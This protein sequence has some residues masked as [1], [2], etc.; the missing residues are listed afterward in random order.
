MKLEDAIAKSIYNY[1]S[2]FKDSNWEKSRIKVLD[3]LFLTIGN[4]YEWYDGYLTER[5]GK[6]VGR[7]YKKPEKYGKQ[8]FTQ[9][10]DEVFFTKPV[11]REASWS[12]EMKILIKDNPKFSGLLEMEE[13]SDYIPT[14]YPVCEYSA[15]ITAPDN[16]RSDWLAGAIETA[17]WAKSFHEGPPA[18]VMASKF[19]RT[20]GISGKAAKT[21]INRQLTTICKALS[22]LRLIEKK[23]KKI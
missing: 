18:Q 6:K 19:I 17:E 3:H 13:R 23:L 5:V 12:E 22:Q 14:P 20:E 2:L 21:H 1:P 10:P 8:K 15:I 11:Y 9:R 7:G 16:I 4:G